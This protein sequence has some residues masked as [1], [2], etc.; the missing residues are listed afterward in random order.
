L[1]PSGRTSAMLFS[2]VRS[3][4]P[5][6][7]KYSVGLVG[8]IIV[9]TFV[10]IAVFAPAI[11]THNP[12]EQSLLNALRPPNGSHWLGTD[13]LGRDTFS[14]LVFGSRTSLVVAGSSA[15]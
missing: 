6:V 7:R 10:M 2:M 15:T 5:R 1:R 13:D 14:R 8:A 3:T 11:A 4:W 9:G 12:L